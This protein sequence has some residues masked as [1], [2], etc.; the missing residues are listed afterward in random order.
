[1]ALQPSTGLPAYNI[2]SSVKKKSWAK[3]RKGK[4]GKIPQTVKEIY[5]K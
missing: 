5:R 1:M 3:K 4:K 2:P